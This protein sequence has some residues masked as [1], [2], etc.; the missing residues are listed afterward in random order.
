MEVENLELLKQALANG[1]GVVLLLSHMGN[2]ELLSRI[3]HLFPE[4]TKTGA[5]Y[6]PLNNRLMDE[7]VLRRREA[8]G[9]RMFSK[10]DPFH[11]VTGFLREGG[12]V[13]VLADQRVGIQG[14]LVHFFGRMTRASPLPSLLA[15]RSKSAVL[16][17]SV[18]T[19]APGKWR[20]IF[21]PVETPYTT[22][23]CT[24]AL[25]ESM[26][27]GPLDVFWLQERWK[28]YVEP[29]YPWNRWIENGV[30]D[31]SKRHRV[32]LWLPGVPGSWRLPDDWLHPDV[33]YE[34]A[35]SAGQQRPSWLPETMRVHE[36]HPTEDRDMLRKT[37]AKIDAADALPLDFILTTE[38]PKLLRKA[39]KREAVPVIS[40]P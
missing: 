24:A 5:F 13:G 21:L 25:E 37:I 1:K 40:L 31:E 11:Q 17:L 6:R 29:N 27:T 19:V 9:T 23:H 10:R 30:S 4:G 34:A 32:L 2:W 15:R 26:K 3:V 22:E 8:D 12:V 14:E 39:A 16:A 36:V 33:V 18:T 28:V 38:A 35:V 20:A 7:R